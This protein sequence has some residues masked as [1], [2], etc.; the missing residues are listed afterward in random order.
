MGMH[1][2]IRPQNFWSWDDFPQVLNLTMSAP[3]SDATAASFQ[4]ELSSAVSGRKQL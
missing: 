4:I 3:L 2:E 1:M